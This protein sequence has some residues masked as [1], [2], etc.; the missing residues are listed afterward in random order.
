MRSQHLWNK[1]HTFYTENRKN[2][3][4]CDLQSLFYLKIFHLEYPDK[5]QLTPVFGTMSLWTTVPQLPSHYGFLLAAKRHH[6]LSGWGEQPHGLSGG[7]VVSVM[8]DQ[9]LLHSEEGNCPAPHVRARH[10]SAELVLQCWAEPHCSVCALPLQNHH[11]TH[12]EQKQKERLMLDTQPSIFI[13][14]V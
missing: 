5:V 4:I 14:P 13:S 10:P 2:N 6:V 3:V 9:G 7:L 11:L 1:F 12:A 8:E